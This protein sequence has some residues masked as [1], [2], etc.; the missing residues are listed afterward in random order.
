MLLNQYDYNLPEDLIAQYPALSRE[1]SKLLVLDKNTGRVTHKMFSDLPE[2]LKP[3]DLLVVNNTRVFPAR[4]IGYRKPSGGEAE[5]FLLTPH[6]DGTWDALSRPARRLKKGSVITFGGEILQAEII[7]KGTEGHVRVRLIAD[8]DIDAAVEQ[9]GRTPLPPYIRHEP[10]ESDR[11]RYQTVY[12]TQKGAVAAPTAGLHFTKNVLAKLENRGINRAEVT[13]HVGIGT[14]RPLSK[15]T[16]GKDT[17]HMEYCIVP[18]ETVQA[19]HECRKNG[20]RVIA[21]GTTTARALESAARNSLLVPF[22]GWTDIFIKPPYTFR[23]VD[24]LVTNFHLP[25]S[26]LLMMAS[27]LAGRKRLLSAYQEAIRMRYRFYSYGD[28][29][30]ISGGTG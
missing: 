11:E 13:L 26:S 7:E 15:K 14:F 4:L 8:G 18:E 20:G 2:L 10:D 16:A 29:M 28:A 5:I 19:I 25:R 27:A 17:L 23:A 3:G 12:A 30:L 6:E 1:Q 24:S 9:V 22:T 21:V